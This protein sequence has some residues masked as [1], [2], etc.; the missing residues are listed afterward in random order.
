MNKVELSVMVSLRLKY[1]WSSES[2]P[3]IQV[4]T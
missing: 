4:I 1:Q 3:N 2:A